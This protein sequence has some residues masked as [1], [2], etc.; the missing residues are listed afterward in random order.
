METNLGRIEL[1]KDINPNG[2]SSLE[3]FIEFNYELYFTAAELW[4]TNSTSSGTNLVRDINLNNIYLAEFDNRL[5]FGADGDENG[6]ELW[7]SDG[8]SEGT[9]LI[10]N[11][12]PATE[13]SSSYPHSSNPSGFT[14]F[15]DKLYFST[16]YGL[17]AIARIV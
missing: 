7:V 13:G 12:H 11:I 14:E 15:N 5:Y 9:S 10:K 1:V 2:N 4:V 3:N 17:A 8:T 6:R 16:D